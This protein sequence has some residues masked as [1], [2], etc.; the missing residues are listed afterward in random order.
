MAYLLGKKIKGISI[1]HPLG[2]IER[3]AESELSDLVKK[4]E[5]GD[6]KAKD[7]LIKGHV[8]LAIHIAGQYAVSNPRVAH[9]LV[10]EA[11][12][13][14]TEGCDRWMK[15]LVES[16]SFTGYIVCRIH[17]KCTYLLRKMKLFG[18]SHSGYIKKR[19]KSEDGTVVVAKQTRLMGSVT[20]ERRIGAIDRGSRNGH[21][22]V[23]RLSLYEL[24][25]ILESTTKT[26]LQSEILRLKM[27]GYS[28]AEVSR[29]LG[30]PLIKVYRDLE[31]IRERFERIEKD[32]EL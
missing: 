28:V 18:I 29:E 25:D 10:S 6:V 21:P 3:V 2:T 26:D 15:G 12:F 27:M 16:E 8:K 31:Q 14:I 9:D 22:W 5:Q 23:M 4:L 20:T 7:A 32:L 30:I 11:M 17:S 24:K 13:A 19:N 1:S